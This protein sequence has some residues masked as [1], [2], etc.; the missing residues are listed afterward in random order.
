MVRFTDVMALGEKNFKI[1]IYIYMFLN[2]H[3][4][5]AYLCAKRYLHLILQY[6]HICI[7]FVLKVEKNKPG[8]ETNG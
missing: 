5:V 8:A 6:I 1:Y 2:L 3:I 4:T 7:Y